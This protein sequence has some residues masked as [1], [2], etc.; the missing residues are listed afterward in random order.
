VAVHARWHQPYIWSSKA[1]TRSLVVER[2]I[3]ANLLHVFDLLIGARGRDDLQSV[4]L[5]QLDNE[6]G[7]GGQRVF[8][9]GAG[10]ARSRAD[11]ASTTRHEYSFALSRCSSD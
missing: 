11:S 5:G 4:L 3:R 8:D 9:R 1:R 7:D 6:A 2:D 10:S